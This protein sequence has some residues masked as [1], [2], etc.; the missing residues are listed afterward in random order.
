MPAHRLHRPIAVFDAGIGSYAIVAEI[1]RQ[2]PRQDIVYFADRA[3]FPY[4]AKSPEA[5]TAIMASTL[6]YLERFDPSAIVMASN[7]PS[8]T[9]LETVR[10]LT[11]VP[12]YGVFPP[13]AEAIACSC[14]REVG[15]MGVTSLI[16]SDGL[17]RFIAANRPPE[18]TVTAI[19][20][21]S[22][23]ELVESG[24][25][26]FDPTGTQAHVDAFID[27]LFQRAPAIDV[28]TLS[29]THLP[30]LK[31]FFER[32]RPG[33]RFLDPAERIVAELGESEEGKGRVRTLVTEDARYAVTDFRRML[34]RLGVELELEVVDSM[35]QT[36]N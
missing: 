33:C 21:S 13:L 14:S 28:L 9:V 36:A 20:A 8:I 5:L 6:H 18:A 22:M 2:R 27:A 10:S 34:E 30:W 32:A 7:A 29:S 17:Q 31:P 25:F 26:L 1:Q 15:I 19:D 12:L 24:A 4:G 3:S 11:T 23:V 16:D 35:T